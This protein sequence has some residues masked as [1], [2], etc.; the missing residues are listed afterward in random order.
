MHCIIPCNHCFVTVLDWLIKQCY[1][2]TSLLEQHIG[3]GD[4]WIIQTS[5][6]GFER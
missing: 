4:C 3:G 6:P 1:V 5:Q 2:S